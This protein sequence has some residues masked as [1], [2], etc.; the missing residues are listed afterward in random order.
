MITPMSDECFLYGTIVGAFGTTADWYGPFERN[1]QVIAS[2][3]EADEA[4]QLT[5]GMF[6][7]PE[8]YGQPGFYRYQV[9]HF[10]ASFN[11][12]ADDWHV[13][14]EKFEGLLVRLCWFEAH[15]HLDAGIAGGRHSFQWRVAPD[16]VARMRQ[17]PPLPPECWDFEGGPRKFSS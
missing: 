6:G 13:W 5:R 4:P 11:H 9:I 14:L 3:P 7:L 16:Q 10:G 8:R 15:V 2:L 1:E 12:F 17:K